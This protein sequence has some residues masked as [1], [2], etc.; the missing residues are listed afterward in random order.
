MSAQE[1]IHGRPRILSDGTITY[2]KKGWEPPPVPEGYRRK[3]SN[4]R[5][6]DAWVFIPVLQECPRRSFHITYTICG[7]A[8]LSYRCALHGDVKPPQCKSCTEKADAKMS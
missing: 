6:S 1:I 4:L 5:S 7:A 3:G 8:R 2:P